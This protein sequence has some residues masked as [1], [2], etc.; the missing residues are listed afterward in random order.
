V[1]P[2]CTNGTG[3]ACA[4]TVC[5]CD[6]KV[7]I[8]CGLFPEP[9]AYTIPLNSFDGADPAGMTCDPTANVGH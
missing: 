8:G 1:S 2:I 7:L 4:Q 5:G 3:G 6:G 9:F